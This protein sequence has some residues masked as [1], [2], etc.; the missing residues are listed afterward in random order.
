MQF[1]GELTLRGFAGT[2]VNRQVKAYP[3]NDT[4]KGLSYIVGGITKLI[5]RNNKMGTIFVYRH[6]K[7]QTLDCSN[8]ECRFVQLENATALRDL[9]CSSNRIEIFHFRSVPQLKRLNCANNKITPYHFDGL[10]KSLPTCPENDHGQLCVKDLTQIDENVFSDENFEAAKAKNWDVYAVTM[11][12]EG[13]YVWIPYDGKKV[14]ISDNLISYTTMIPVWTIIDLEIQARGDLIADG[15]SN[16]NFD[17]GYFK[18][19]ILKPK[20]FIQGDLT[21]LRFPG[22]F[23]E[24]DFSKNKSLS[25]FESGGGAVKT[26]DFGNSPSIIEIALPYNQLET[27][28]V[29]NCPKLR[30][31]TCYNNN[32]SLE[33]VRKVINDL[34]DHS[35]GRPPGDGSRPKASKLKLIGGDYPDE[36][37]AIPT[38]DLL[39]LA[40]Q[41][42]WEILIF[43]PD[44]DRDPKW[45]KMTKQD[46]T[47]VI[48]PESNE[49]SI[50]PNPAGDF[51]S[52]AGAEAR[53]TV[54]LT[55]LT[56]RVL[57][58]S[59]CDDGGK[60]KLDVRGIPAGNYLLVVNGTSHKL[61]IA[62][63][64]SVWWSHSLDQI[65]WQTQI[66]DFFCTFV[67]E[68]FLG[69]S[70]HT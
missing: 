31:L 57:V 50:S 14:V 58:K 27:I 16:I 70:T 62:R 39:E 60:V 48:L 42:N 37:N 19:T 10:I 66:C 56:G 41:K 32:L 15:L 17:R 29:E 36:R 2:P 5:A 43:R 1:E 12:S 68:V 52:I 47:S 44:S 51:V 54:S 25:L 38:E 35:S 3:P 49:S 33:A 23:S 67:V 40:E 30:V 34:P 24:I 59:Q 69:S 22:G 64:G 55:D 53:A 8:N 9:D 18:S 4:G 45:R 13:N 6:S 46:I 61:L 7:L 11:D 21:V 26:L 65:M 63:W 28:N 20:A